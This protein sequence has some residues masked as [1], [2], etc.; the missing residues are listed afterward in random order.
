[1]AVPDLVQIKDSLIRLNLNPGRMPTLKEYKK[2][3]R[4]KLNL[5]PDL[6][7]ETAVFQEITEAARTIFEFI[8]KHQDKQTRPDSDK[9]RNLLRIFESSNNVNYNKGNVVFD[10]DGS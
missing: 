4:E 10:I 2:A 7:G 1:M 3:F 8:S 9:D 6:G 5:H